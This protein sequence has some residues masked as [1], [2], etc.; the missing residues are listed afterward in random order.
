MAQRSRAVEAAE[1]MP[2]CLPNRDTL[3]GWQRQ[4]KPCPRLSAQNGMHFPD[5]GPSGN[6]IPESDL[7]TGQTFRMKRPA[8]TA[9]RNRGSNWDAV[10]KQ[11]TS[12]KRVP[13]RDLIQE[14]SFRLRTGPESASHSGAGFRDIVSTEDPKR[15]SHPI[16][17][18][19]S[20][21]QL[22]HAE[23]LQTKGP[24]SRWSRG[25]WRSIRSWR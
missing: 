10:S 13:L 11:T 24:G 3:S 14:H 22:P 20:G 18:A 7:R 17:S 9:P 5:G 23:A 1:L 2:A 15:K 16:L 25:Q 12:G 21:T 19:N 8:E 6:R 4:R